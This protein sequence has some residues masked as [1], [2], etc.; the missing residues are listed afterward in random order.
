MALHCLG[1]SMRM[2]G[3]LLCRL[4]IQVGYQTVSSGAYA[5]SQQFIHQCLV[6]TDSAA[7]MVLMNVLVLMILPASLECHSILWD[8]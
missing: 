7:L 5:S 4:A 3:R 6:D 2:P 8:L 1:S